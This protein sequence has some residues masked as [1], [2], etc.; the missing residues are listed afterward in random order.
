MQKADRKTKATIGIL[1]ER[2][3]FD[4][5]VTQ[6]REVVSQHRKKP[7]QWVHQ[8]NYGNQRMQM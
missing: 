1:H 7:T 3:R 4:Q 6:N 8:I 5:Y 2:L